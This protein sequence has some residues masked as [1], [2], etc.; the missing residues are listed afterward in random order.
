MRTPR[1]LVSIPPGVAAKI[2]KLVGQ[3]HRS[4]FIV[5]VLECEIMRREQLAALG[6]AAG[7]WKDEDHPELAQGSEA[8]VR[9]LG[10]KI[11]R[12]SNRSSLLRNNGDAASR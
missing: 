12:A 1:T 11:S 7:G 5:E 4:E 6:L 2:D 3:E 10:R 9:Q 8:Y